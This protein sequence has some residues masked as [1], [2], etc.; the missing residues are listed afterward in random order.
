M[1]SR[2]SSLITQ[3][4]A[5]ITVALAPAAAETYY[6]DS[7]SVG[8]GWMRT[9]VQYD[10]GSPSRIGI[11]M[12]AAAFQAFASAP[13]SATE[14]LLPSQAPGRYTFALVDWNPEGHPGPGYNVP[15]FDFHFYFTSPEEVDAI[16]FNPAPTHANPAYVPENYIPDLVAVPQMGLHY[17]DLTAPEFNGGSFTRTF[18]YGFNEG[19]LTFL[20]PMITYA[21]LASG[22]PFELAVRQPAHFERAGY[23]PTEYGFSFV[24]G[25]YDVH[26][27]NL[28]PVAA[29]PVP[30]PST[31]GIAASF[32]LVTTVLWSRR[33]IRAKAG[34]AL[35]AADSPTPDRS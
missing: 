14:L 17:L 19:W 12:N 1:K 4:L 21:T 13:E 31:Y 8:D 26:L 25:V 7:T 29:S 23:Y 20:E 15:H 2:Y 9:Y 11:Q 35:T 22:D 3:A 5:L 34:T 10:A 30:E 18:I 27:G 6:G 32:L 24:D 16:P 28:S 33:R